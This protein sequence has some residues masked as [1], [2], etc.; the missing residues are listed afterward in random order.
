MIGLCGAHRVGKSSL[1]KAYADAAKIPF[2]ATSAS[3]VFKEHGMDPSVTYSFEER[4]FIQDKILDHLGAFFA[5]YAC[6]EVITDRTPLDMIAYLMAD[7]IGEAVPD[8]LQQQFKNYIEKCFALANRR[9]TSLVLVQP[10][11]KIV[12]ADGKAA[13]NEAYIEHLNTVLLGL[14]IDPRLKVPHYYIPRIWTDMDDRVRAVAMAVGKTK[15][16]AHQD[17]MRQVEGGELVLH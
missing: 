15:E 2:V 14:T 17:W 3:A 8:K 11:I 7:A 10:G 5:Q 12:A 13:A 6:E 1:A 9:F 16:R 4:M